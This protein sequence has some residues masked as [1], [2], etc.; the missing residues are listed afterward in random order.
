MVFI[1]LNKSTVKLP[2]PNSG[3]LVHKLGRER[4]SA[5]R[6]LASSSA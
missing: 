1:A 6:P 4:Y 3:S 2:A 5:S